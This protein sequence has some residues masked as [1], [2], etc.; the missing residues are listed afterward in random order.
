MRFTVGTRLALGFGSMVVLMLVLAGSAW[1]SSSK[2]AAGISDVLTRNQQM[3]AAANLE[4]TAH[5]LGACITEFLVHPDEGTLRQYA[6]YRQRF[7]SYLADF[8]ASV[9]DDAER[10]FMA[11]I[12]SAS[13][14]I[15][16][17]FDQLK[18]LTQ[19]I[20]HL[21]TVDMKAAGD[22]PIAALERLIAD[23]NAANNVPARAAARQGKVDFLEARLAAVRFFDTDS[24]AEATAALRELD[25]SIAGLKTAAANA[26]FG[27]LAPRFSPVLQDVEAFAGYFRRYAEEDKQILALLKDTVTP[28]RLEVCKLCEELGTDV[29]G[30]VMKTGAELTGTAATARTLSVSLGVGAII[31]GVAMGLF[32]ARSIVRPVRA[33]IGRITAIQEAKDLT[34][35]VEAIAGDEIGDLARTFNELV[36]T[37]H[38]II[39]EVGSGSVQLDAGASQIA[40]SSQGLAEGSSEQASSLEEISASLEEMSSMTEQNAEHARQASTLSAQS[41]SSADRGQR[42]MMDMSRA[43]GEI[44]QSAGEISRIIKV[45][46]EIAFQTNL[47]ALNAAVEAAR[48]GEA[49]KGFAVVAE[50]VRNLARRSAEAAKNTSSMIE[51]SSRRADNGVEIAQRVGAALEEI[52][53][54]TTKVNTLL[55]EIASASSEQSSGIGQVNTG[56]SQ[57]DQVTQANAGNSEELASNAEEMSSQVAALRGLVAQ[58]RVNGVQSGGRGTGPRAASSPATSGALRRPGQIAAGVS[59]PASKR[60]AAS[61]SA[62]APGASAESL[63]PMN[64]DEV[65]ASF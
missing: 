5:R 1:V 15:W 12:E 47:L 23:A 28:A 7:E 51:E 10:E 14:R 16:T 19:D 33:L 29:S 6:E 34:Q 46:D 25:E 24:E 55:A 26:E 20:H 17:S 18:A 22:E 42:E 53:G 50:E 63:I 11:D 2:T 57:L 39:A 30:D 8:G 61:G 48:A 56:V 3:R 9:R 27:D 43:M 37:L 4:Q 35:R 41:K 52:V 32:I 60:R 31:A 45:I 49:G 58:F 40:A 62:G 38:D 21:R 64:D 59:R 13:R 44:K 54:G 65:L 36:S